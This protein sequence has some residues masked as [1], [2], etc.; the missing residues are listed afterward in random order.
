MMPLFYEELRR[1]ARQLL[2]LDAEQ[3]CMVEP[4]FFGAL[5]I[6]ES[7]EAVGTSPDPLK[8]HWS[9]ARIWLYQRLNANAQ[10]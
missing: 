1:V 4:R 3:G 10:I 8:R 9:S 2:Q 5:S 7:T 6:E